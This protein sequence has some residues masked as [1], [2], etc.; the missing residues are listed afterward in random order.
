MFKRNDEH[1]QRDMFDPSMELSPQM[2]KRLDES[3]AGTFYREF[4]CRLDETI[5]E[6]LYSDAPSRPNV[7]VNQLVAFEVLKAGQ[8]LTDE[9]AYDE[10]NFNLQ[11]RRAMGLRTW[12]ETPFTL[13]T[14]YN[15]RKAVSD[16]AEREKVDLFVKAFEQVTGEQQA[17]FEIGS[18]KVRMDS[19]QV[20][21]NMSK[22]SRVRLLSS[23]LER[24]HRELDEADRKRLAERFGPYGGDAKK[25]A[26]QVRTDE[27]HGHVIAIGELMAWLLEDL[28]ETYGQSPAYA[29][30]NRVFGEHFIG[31]SDGVMH[32]LDREIDAQSLQSPDDPDA[33]YRRKGAKA[34]QGYVA[35]VAETCDQENEQQLIVDVQVEPNSADDA[36]MLVEGA[37]AL[38][39]R[40]QMETLY[41]DGGYNSAAA[42]EKLAELG[43]EQVQT[44]IRGSRP[45]QLGRDAFEW[46]LDDQQRPLAVTCPEHQRVDVEQG[47]KS[48]TFLARFDGEVCAGCPL[49][50]Y[51]PAK[52]VGRKRQHVLRFTHRQVQSALRQ[53][54]SRA[55]QRTGSN[56]RAA[57]EATMWSLKS[58]MRRQRAPYRG[59][60]RVAM[61]MVSSA[62]MINI[63]RLTKLERQRNDGGTLPADRF[64]LYRPLRRLLTDAATQAARRIIR[65]LSRNAHHWTPADRRPANMAAA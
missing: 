62:A 29:M 2:Q 9:Q 21:S 15:F 12:G 32:R 48:H 44:G 51:C 37:E 31:F 27:P 36:Q 24:M 30:M 42:D 47:R 35:N 46:E 50:K 54:R 55:Q 64:G 13:R 59:R 40:T 17:A 6:V 41:T 61:F 49:E 28:E 16:Y 10:V 26:Y 38:V 52:K 58:T 34:Y 33:T 4:F 23:V 39:E 45:R 18:R 22:L 25:F 5:F 57:V 8:G 65:L 63:R 19:T 53:Q 3:W 14:V 1:L 60:E 11:V 20:A 56:P 7:P 43:V